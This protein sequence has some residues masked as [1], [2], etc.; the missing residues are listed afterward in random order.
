MEGDGR[1][2]SIAQVL[3]GLSQRDQMDTQR[4]DS[5][6]EVGKGAHIMN[7]EHLSLDQVVE[8]IMALMEVQ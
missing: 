3:A 4:A 1:I 2:L 8:Q 6:L 7:T 5:P